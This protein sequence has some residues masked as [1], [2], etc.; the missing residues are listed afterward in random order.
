M[1][2]LLLPVSAHQPQSNPEVL[3]CCL[4]S[5]ARRRTK[6]VTIQ[7][8]YLFNLLSIL[9]FPQHSPNNDFIY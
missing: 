1:F 8:R 5:C 2:S 9:P 7:V 3:H 4:R 6:Y